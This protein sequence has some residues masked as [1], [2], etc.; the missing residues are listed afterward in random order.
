VV[1]PEELRQVS[2]AAAWSTL[3]LDSFGTNDHNWLVGHQPSEY[4]T[5]LNRTI[6]D[7]RYRWEAQ[8]NRPSSMTT[9]WLMGYPLAEF[10]LIVNGKHIRGRRAG[11][12]WGVVFRIQD[13]QNYYW[14]RVTDT[15]F[16]AVSVIEDS[17]WLDLVEWTRSEAIKPQGVNQI[18]VV[19]SG[20]H[21]TF[22]PG[23]TDKKTR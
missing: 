10:H 7:G 5:A 8:V 9:A 15:Q 20:T 13:N 17:Q 2:G 23:Y 3:V 1:I 12:A 18:E 19:A 4:F 16:F 6:T 14:F 11:S 22:L 21:F